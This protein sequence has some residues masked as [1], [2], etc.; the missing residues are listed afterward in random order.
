MRDDYEAEGQSLLAL[1]ALALLA[2][3]FAGCPKPT[4]AP[5]EPGVL[6][7]A[8]QAVRDHWPQVLPEVNKCLA[9]ASD[10]DWMGCLTGLIVPAAGITE[11]V[12]ACLVHSSGASYADAAAHNP[13]DGISVRAAQRAAT[14]IAQRGYQFR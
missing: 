4:P 10:G 6:D 5:G 2:M 3:L 11:E 8:S 7:C 14:F 1:I 9:A 12:V 13:H